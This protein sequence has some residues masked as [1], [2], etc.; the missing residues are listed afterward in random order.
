VARQQAEYDTMMMMMMMMIMM[1]MMMMMM[2][3]VMVMMMMMMTTSLAGTYLHLF[4][5]NEI[6][7][8]ISVNFIDELHHI[9][10]DTAVYTLCIA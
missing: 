10:K 9:E 5:L 2:M 6:S 7:Y 8:Y 3:V 1:M 4:L